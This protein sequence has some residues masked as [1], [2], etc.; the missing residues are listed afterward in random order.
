[1]QHD[2]D[3]ITDQEPIKSDIKAIT[4]I[5]KIHSVNEFVQAFAMT[6]GLTLRSSLDAVMHLFPFLTN[7]THLNQVNGN[8]ELLQ[9]K[10]NQLQFEH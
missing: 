2:L 7:Y 5:G 9:I 10:A 8:K 3:Y 6:Y 4:S 1:M